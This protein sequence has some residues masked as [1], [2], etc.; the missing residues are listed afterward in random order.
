[1]RFYRLDGLKAKANV[2][3]GN[4]KRA[5]LVKEGFFNALLYVHNVYGGDD[6]KRTSLQRIITKLSPLPIPVLPNRNPLDANVTGNDANEENEDIEMETGT[7][8]TCDAKVAVN[9]E[10]PSL[11]SASANVILKE[12]LVSFCPVTAAPFANREEINQTVSINDA[13]S[14]VVDVIRSSRKCDFC[15]I[16][17]VPTS[18]EAIVSASFIPGGIAPAFTASVPIYFALCS[19]S[20]KQ[21][22]LK[23]NPVV[24]AAAPVAIAAAVHVA[25]V[26]KTN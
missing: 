20:C 10:V 9:N 3:S 14:E 1:V 7:A 6:E 25:P 18:N 13:P 16:Q 21:A 8:R 24:I 2:I 22:L 15:R 26:P 11:L 4:D 5:F 23:S 17:H 12:E 19:P